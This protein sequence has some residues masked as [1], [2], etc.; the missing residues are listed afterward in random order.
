MQNFKKSFFFNSGTQPLRSIATNLWKFNRVA[1][2][3]TFTH[4]PVAVLLSFGSVGGE[5]NLK[6]IVKDRLKEL[7]G[8]RKKV[9]DNKELNLTLVS[10]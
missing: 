9:Q 3:L 8:L 1:D 6:E 4:V 7:S 2:A 10:P 5:Q